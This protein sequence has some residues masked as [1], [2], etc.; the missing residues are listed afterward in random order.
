MAKRKRRAAALKAKVA[1][2]AIR[3]EK[4]ANELAGL[5]QLHPT[6]IAAWK[7]QALQGMT[8]IFADGRRKR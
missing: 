4:T 1:L 5:Y 2:E 7:K 6:Q 8:E 3:G